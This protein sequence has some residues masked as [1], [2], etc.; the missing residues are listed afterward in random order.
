VKTTKKKA[1]VVFAFTSEPGARFR[2]SLDG[3]AYTSCP[4]T[5]TLGVKAGRHTLS[6]E[7]VDA[8][9]NVSA[10]ATVAWKVKGMRRH[11]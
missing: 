9:G 3:A 2:C 5:L 10:P 8:L 7:A 4:A 1:K 6:V 11:G